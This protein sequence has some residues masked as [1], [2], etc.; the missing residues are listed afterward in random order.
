VVGAVVAVLLVGIVD[1]VTGPRWSM[2]VFYLVPVAWAAAVVGRRV[3]LCLV[4]L[5]GVSGLLADVVFQPASTDRM[6]AFWNV[7]FMVGTLVVVVELV[8]RVGARRDAALRA[9]RQRR[10]F[11][12][13]AAQQLQAPVGAIDAAIG[14]FDASEESDE[15]LARVAAES[16]RA[17]RLA[18]ALL[19][20]ARLDQHEPT[21]GRLSELRAVVGQA[22][23]RAART[24]PGLQWRLE[25]DAEVS[26]PCDPDALGEALAELLENAGRHAVSRVDVTVS[27]GSDRVGVMVHDDG[28]GLPA[29]ATEVIF[30][31]FVSLDGHGGTGLGLPIARGIAE[32]HGGSLV[33][34]NRSFVLTLPMD[35][36]PSGLRAD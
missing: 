2:L 8:S 29:S 10:E 30:E 34:A 33:Y 5:V 1:Y 36:G 27:S 15:A 20:L 3:G 19:R 24:R 16:A 18:S 28:S 12:G 25:P 26:L 22:V 23:D 32:A 9:E 11:V 17:G 14:V 13:L 21:R 6:V 7:M 4:G 31:R 35:P